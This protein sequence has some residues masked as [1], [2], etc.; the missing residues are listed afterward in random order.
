[1][2]NKSFYGSAAWLKCRGI[3]LIRDHYLCQPCL[4][5]GELKPA[6]IVHHIEPIDERPD[7]A[8]DPDNCETICPSCHNKEHPEK[9]GGKRKKRLKVQVYKA[10]GNQEWI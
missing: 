1:M 3:V 6:N 8:L 5:Q 9:G 2:S 4:K 10:K 7:Q